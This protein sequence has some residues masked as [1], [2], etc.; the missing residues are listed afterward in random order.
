M[1]DNNQSQLLRMAHQWDSYSFILL[2]ISTVYILFAP[3]LGHVSVSTMQ[4]AR[5]IGLTTIFILIAHAEATSLFVGACIDSS[6]RCDE[7]KTYMVITKCVAFIS[8]FIGF[9]LLL[10]SS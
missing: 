5:P 10:L 8:V 9:I 7:Y 1:K 6:K 4:Y 3:Y 2:V